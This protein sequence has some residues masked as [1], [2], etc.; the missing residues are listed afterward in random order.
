M[1]QDTSS[2][3]RSDTRRRMVVGAAKMISS[4]GVDAMSLRVLAEQEDV[5]LGSTYHY[6]P[7]G[8]AELV[9]E[10][11]SLVGARVTRLM[12]DA[13]D[14]GPELLLGVFADNWR[15]ALEQS[16]FRSGCAVLAAATATDPRHHVTARAVF[17][18]WHRTLAAVLVDAGVPAERAS[19]L[20]RTMVATVE[21]AVA[22]ARA[23]GTADPL[24][25]VVVELAD[26]VK[27][28]ARLEGQS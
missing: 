25:D 8:K 17:E 18:D 21:G 20:A 26:L 3:P 2:K 15:T 27:A 12:E 13:R 11:V 23:T 5:P 6:F 24:D 28:A 1:T 4:G 7:G 19:R 14:R 9:D 16:G 22:M 10:A